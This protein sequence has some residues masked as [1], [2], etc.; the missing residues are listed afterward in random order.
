MFKIASK[1]TV[2]QMETDS[3]KQVLNTGFLVLLLDAVVTDGG[4]ASG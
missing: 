4:T 2:Q 3:V 1:L